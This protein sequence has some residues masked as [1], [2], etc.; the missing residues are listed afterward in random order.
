MIAP[1]EVCFALLQSYS[2]QSK[3]SDATEAVGRKFVP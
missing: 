1:E 2:P 3:T